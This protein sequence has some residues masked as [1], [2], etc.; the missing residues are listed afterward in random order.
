M[1]SLLPTWQAYSYSHTLQANF[2]LPANSFRIFSTHTHACNLLSDQGEWIALVDRQHGNGPF[3]VVIPSV[4]LRQRQPNEIVHV[5]NGF[6][7]FVERW[8]DLRA[9][10]VWEPR[11]ESIIISRNTLLSLHER[12][13]SISSPLFTSK[14]G[15]LPTLPAF[16]RPA[17]ER[18]WQ[19]LQ[20]G[21]RKEIVHAAQQLAGLGPGLTPA[22]DDFLIGLMAAL[23][24]HP[25]V[26]TQHLSNADICAAIGNAAAQ[27][28]TR[29]SAQWLRCAALGEFGAAWHQLARAL[30]KEEPAAMESALKRILASGATSGADALMG[31]GMGLAID[32]FQ[33]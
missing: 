28:T 15:N 14:S 33:I 19:G 20:Q 9:A 23:T 26:L 22:G 17:S 32:K 29:L 2:A 8:L 25:P 30:E 27:Q 31:F 21:D 10:A 4:L 3:H 16:A 6:L 7:H 18:L 11:L 12:L 1:S 24:L 13:S 5:A